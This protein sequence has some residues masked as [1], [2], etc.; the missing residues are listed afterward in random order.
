M[1]IGNFGAVDFYPSPL[2]LKIRLYTNLCYCWTF[3][4]CMSLTQTNLGDRHATWCHF[5]VK[6]TKAPRN[7]IICLILEKTV[8]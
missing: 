6:E 7:L 1:A 4:A 3:T 2:P 5:I 8:L